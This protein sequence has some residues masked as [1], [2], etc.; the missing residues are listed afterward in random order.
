MYGH[1]YQIKS[2]C[3][4]SLYSLLVLKLDCLVSVYK[5]LF[6]AIY[7]GTNS[8]RNPMFVLEYGSQ[9]DYSVAGNGCV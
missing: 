2:R 3:E 6:F 7:I 9:N 5:I 4:I 8:D 1:L